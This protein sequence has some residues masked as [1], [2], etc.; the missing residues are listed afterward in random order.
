LSY[1]PFI[2][3]PE[4]AWVFWRKVINTDMATPEEIRAH[5]EETLANSTHH[6]VRKVDPPK[7]GVVELVEK[8]KKAV[9]T[10]DANSTA[11]AL[12]KEDE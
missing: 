12:S 3:R 5:V 11:E 9:A 6:Y 7:P 1:A 2:P 8:K 4:E 10:A